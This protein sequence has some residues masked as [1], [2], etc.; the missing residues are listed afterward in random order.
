MTKP[1]VAIS[2]FIVTISSL[3]LFN[4]NSPPQN[5]DTSLK[6]PYVAQVGSFMDSSTTSPTTS[7][8]ATKT[9]APTTPPTP[10][11]TQ[12]IPLE[13]VTGTPTPTVALT[14]ISTPT[15]APTPA[16]VPTPSPTSTPTPQNSSTL[17]VVSLTTPIAQKQD[18][19]IKIKSV[20]GANCSIEVTWPSGTVSTSK[21]LAPKTAD[22]NGELAWT[23]GINWNTKPGTAT[24]KLS[25]ASDGQTYSGQTTM[26]IIASQ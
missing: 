24:I 5:N 16:P 17:I 4:K 20:P 18:A 11:P 22:T 15:K 9:L 3:L 13:T 14:A 26:T 7:T 6:Q 25:C 8:T 21:D 1:I 23:W 19:T 12:L 2:V 10:T